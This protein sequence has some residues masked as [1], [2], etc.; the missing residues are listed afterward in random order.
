VGRGASKS[1]TGGERLRVRYMRQDF[2]EYMP[3]FELLFAGNHK[4]EL[5]NLDDAM[6]RRFVLL[7]FERRPDVVDLK[8]K[9]TLRAEWPGI[10]AWAIKGCLE[11]NRVGLGAPARVSKAT[12]EYFD[13]EDT[14]GKWA[15]ERVVILVEGH[16]RSS[17]LFQDW[18]D[19]CSRSNEIPGTQKRF[20][21]ALIAR[22][23]IPCRDGSGTRFDGIALLPI[24]TDEFPM[25]G[26]Y[27]AGRSDGGSPDQQLM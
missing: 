10:L 16:V 25:A 11:W 27:G 21:Q 18:C 24:R 17:T 22:G 19:W 20:S 7:P 6:K 8:L 1:M 2:F 3:Q 5:S 9:D 15:A 26:V 14:I 12:Q 13:D 4:P 23:W